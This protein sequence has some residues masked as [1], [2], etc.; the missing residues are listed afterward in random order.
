MFSVFYRY[1]IFEM[2]SPGSSLNFYMEINI[3]NG[4]VYNSSNQK[5]SNQNQCQ[6]LFLQ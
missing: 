1:K 3:N 4:Y 5:F 2:F 6:A